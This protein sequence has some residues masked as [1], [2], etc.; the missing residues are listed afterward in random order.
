MRVLNPTADYYRFFDAT[1]HAEFLYECVERTI[2]ID[3]PAETDF[4]RGYDAFR[5]QIAEIVNMP[6]RLIDL[7]FRF[8]RQNGGRLSVR[9]R[10]QELRDLTAREIEKVEDLYAKTVQNGLIKRSSP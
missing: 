7:L 5:R 8:L 4:L 9:A 1:P 10:E 3:L 6:D 2:E